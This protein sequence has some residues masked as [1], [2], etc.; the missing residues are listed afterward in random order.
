MRLEELICASVLSRFSHVQLFATPGC[1]PG[2]SVHGIL[3]ARVLQ[4]WVDGPSSR[5]S[6]QPREGT[7]VSYVSCIG[8]RVLYH[9]RH[10]GSLS[11]FV[12]IVVQLL[13]RV[14]FSATLW[15]AACQAFLYLWSHL[16]L[17][18]NGNSLRNHHFK[19]L[20]GQ[21]KPPDAGA[22]PAL[23]MLSEKKHMLPADEPG[24]KSKKSGTE[25]NSQCS[26]PNSPNRRNVAIDQPWLRTILFLQSHLGTNV[27]KMTISFKRDIWLPCDQL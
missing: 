20:L 15:T 1:P 23:G 16:Y 19:A 13:S 24:P 12:A 14:W 6:S 8:R 22:E 9:Q 5:G 21:S 25:P 26:F 4:E 10:L 2:S 27:Y 7:T 3:Q 18:A 17:W 11:S